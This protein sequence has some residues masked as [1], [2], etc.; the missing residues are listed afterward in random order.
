MESG[1]GIVRHRTGLEQARAEL[2][3]LQ[4]AFDRQ[5]G[6]ESSRFL[7]NRQLADFLETGYLLRLARIMALAAAARL[8]SRGAHYREDYPLP[9]DAH[10]LGSSEIELI[11]GMPAIR[12]VPAVPAPARP[13]SARWQGRAG[14]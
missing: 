11:G 14:E 2:E 6:V 3:E 1:V 13:D 4:A 7:F 9:D 12:F 10:W 5:T 8:E